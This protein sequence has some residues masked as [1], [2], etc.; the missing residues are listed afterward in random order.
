MRARLGDPAACGDAGDARVLR[1]V[2]G[3]R[4]HAC[5]A[6]QR[7]GSVPGHRGMAPTHAHHSLGKHA[8]PRDGKVVLDTRKSAPQP[9]A[10]AEAFHLGFQMPSQLEL[11]RGVEPLTNDE[12]DP[13]IFLVRGGKGPSCGAGAGRGRMA[14]G[15]PGGGAS[16]RRRDLALRPAVLSQRR[17]PHAAPC[18]RGGRKAAGHHCH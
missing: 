9:S 10:V 12:I 6:A 7:S 17:R 13:D 3:R 2:W 18:T 1:A 5:S 15:V 4:S 14:P 11:D 16:L 8:V